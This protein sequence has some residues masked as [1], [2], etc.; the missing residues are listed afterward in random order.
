MLLCMQD[1]TNK[2]KYNFLSIYTFCIY[3]FILKK[4]SSNN[5]SRVY[6]NINMGLYSKKML[7][8]YFCITIYFSVH[9]YKKRLEYK[10][11][12]LAILALLSQSYSYAN[13]HRQDLHI[14]PTISHYQQSSDSPQRLS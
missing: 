9:F 2:I 3:I 14:N 6:V 8:F 1:Y 4:V 5:F 11:V 10:E 7:F 12:V 13:T